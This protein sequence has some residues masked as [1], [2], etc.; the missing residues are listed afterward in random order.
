MENAEREFP[1]V[2]FALLANE[3]EPTTYIYGRCDYGG[4][5]DAKGV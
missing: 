3:Q 1:P 2:V 5:L 4:G